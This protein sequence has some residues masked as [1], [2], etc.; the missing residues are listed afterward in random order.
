MNLVWLVCPVKI[1]SFFII[2]VDPMGFVKLKSRLTVQ[3]NSFVHGVD[4]VFPRRGTSKQV[5]YRLWIWHLAL[6][7][8]GPP[9]DIKEWV[10]SDPM[11]LYSICYLVYLGV[12][13]KY[14]RIIKF[15]KIE[16]LHHLDEQKIAHLI[17]KIQS[18]NFTCKPNFYSRKNILASR[19]KDHFLESLFFRRARRRE[20]G[21]KEGP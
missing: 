14:F 20:V 9:W 1:L 10:I 2:W 19:S 17:L 8:R 15:C 7:L 16:I 18:S 13:P 4:F 21:G 3:Y 12:I 11:L 5:Y 6:T